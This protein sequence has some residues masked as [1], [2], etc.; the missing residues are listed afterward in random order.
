MQEIKQ[1]HL[2]KEPTNLP[3][4]ISITTLSVVLISVI[5]LYG[6][7]FYQDRTI[8]NI[9]GQITKL[10]EDIKI[11]SADKDVIVA[12]ILSSTNIRPSIDLKSLKKGF[13]QSAAVAGVRLKGF[14]VNN[15]ILTSSLIATKGSEAIDPIETIIA[16]MRIP[17]QR[18][19]L[20]LEPIYSV[21]GN[22]AERTTNVSFKILSSKVIT[23]ATK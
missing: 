23:N 10:D 12:N 21:A 16:M 2:S 20:S 8:S 18:T 7:T 17:N 22:Q 13:E 15:D 19:G 9:Q 4:I 3:W 5:S 6:Y 11:G 14:V 1:T